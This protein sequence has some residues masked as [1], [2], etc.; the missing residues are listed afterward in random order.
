VTRSQPSRQI[1]KQTLLPDSLVVI[2]TILS[3]VGRF[4]LAAL[5][6][7]NFKIQRDRFSASGIILNPL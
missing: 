7:D 6:T 5:L 2:F 3:I 1:M 4:I